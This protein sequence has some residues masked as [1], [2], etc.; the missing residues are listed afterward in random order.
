MIIGSLK[1]IGCFYKLEACFGECPEYKRNT[2][3]V[4][5]I[6]G[7][8]VVGDSNVIIFLGLLWFLG[9]DIWSRIQKKVALESSGQLH[10]GSRC[11]L[12]E[13]FGPTTHMY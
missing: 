7:P 11:I 13:V 4:G 3:Y 2:Y 9:L 1:Y 5:S 12:T 6:F 10:S 8:L